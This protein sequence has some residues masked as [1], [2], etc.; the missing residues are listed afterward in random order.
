M[1]FLMLKGQMQGM[2]GMW[3]MDHG[4]SESALDSKAERCREAM[5]TSERMFM[6]TRKAKNVTIFLSYE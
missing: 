1:L 3:K 4:K 6:T 5:N 2:L